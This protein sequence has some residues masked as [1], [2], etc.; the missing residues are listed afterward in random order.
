MFFLLYSRSPILPPSTERGLL[1]RI[2]MIL[3]EA[4]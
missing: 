3:F 4:M 2:V 1:Y